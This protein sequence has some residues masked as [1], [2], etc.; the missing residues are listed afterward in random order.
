MVRKKRKFYCEHYSTGVV[1][2]NAIV[3]G[4]DIVEDEIFGARN[5]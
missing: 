4:I 2:G 1:G 5:E 3:R